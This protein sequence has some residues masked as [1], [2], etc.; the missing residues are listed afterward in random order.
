M[1]KF[2]INIIV[3][4]SI[5]PYSGNKVEKDVIRNIENPASRKLGR[6]VVREGHYGEF[7]KAVSPTSITP[8]KKKK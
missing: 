7:Y 2:L 1:N 8:E 4:S 3:L 6:K 5:L